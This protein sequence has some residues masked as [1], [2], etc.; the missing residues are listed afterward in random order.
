[1]KIASRIASTRTPSADSGM[2]ADSDLEV[3]AFPVLLVDHEH[4]APWPA[5]RCS[6][7]A[8]PASRDC[9]QAS[10]AP[11]IV[12]LSHTAAEKSRKRCRIP[13]A[14]APLAERLAADLV[15]AA[16][17]RSFH[18]RIPS[19]PLLAASASF[20]YCNRLDYSPRWQIPKPDRKKG[21]IFQLLIA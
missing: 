14:A 20:D 17:D 11:L 9:S 8:R 4:P 18:L 19:K 1:V 2:V 6:K 5:M 16:L 7:G 12:R 13:T 3:V 15:T 21:D 10:I